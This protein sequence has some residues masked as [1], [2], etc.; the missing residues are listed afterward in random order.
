LQIWVSYGARSIPVRLISRY[1]VDRPNPICLAAA[2][3]DKP[4]LEMR[5]GAEHVE[6]QLW[7]ERTSVN[8]VMTAACASRMLWPAT[9]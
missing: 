2:I 7:P 4:A 8:T 1:T 3:G 6:N 9:S 5:D